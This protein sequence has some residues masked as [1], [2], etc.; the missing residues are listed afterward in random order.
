MFEIVGFP[1]SEIVSIKRRY[2]EI[3]DVKWRTVEQKVIQWKLQS[4]NFPVK[5]NWLRK[6]DDCSVRRKKENC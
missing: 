2:R 3:V 6:N 1:F 5:K 4:E